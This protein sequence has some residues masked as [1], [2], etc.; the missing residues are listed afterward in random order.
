[1]GFKYSTT[2]FGVK[3]DAQTNLRATMENVVNTLIDDLFATH[4]FADE[5]ERMRLFEQEECKN[6]QFEAEK[7]RDKYEKDKRFYWEDENSN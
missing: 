7:L 2:Q 5:N 1:M 6:A 3:R 4:R